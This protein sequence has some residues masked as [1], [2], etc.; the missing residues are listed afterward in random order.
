MSEEI[1]RLSGIWYSILGHHKDCDCHWIIEARYSYGD[2]PTYSAMHY[3][4]VYKEVTVSAATLADVEIALC[5]V[6]KSAIRCRAKWA[7][8]VLKAP[9]SEEW[10]DAQRA[11]AQRIINLASNV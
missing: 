9:P 10:S 8:A 11:E 3:G 5:R 7:E 6:I 4:Y 2:Q 1:V